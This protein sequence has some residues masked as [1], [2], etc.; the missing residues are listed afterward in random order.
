[1]LDVSKSLANPHA[2]AIIIRRH[3]RDQF[4]SKMRS[5]C[6]NATSGMNENNRGNELILK[7]VQERTTQV[8]V[9]DYEYMGDGWQWTELT[10]WLNLTC[11]MPSVR[12]PS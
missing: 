7:S 12:L 8:R 5:H 3:P 9:L 11:P 10:K 6:R 1:M 2:R 4:A